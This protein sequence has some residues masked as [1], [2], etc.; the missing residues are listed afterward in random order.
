[1]NNSVIRAKMLKVDADL[2]WIVYYN[3]GYVYMVLEELYCHQKRN[4]ITFEAAKLDNIQ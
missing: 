1:V 3:C 2:S 4:C